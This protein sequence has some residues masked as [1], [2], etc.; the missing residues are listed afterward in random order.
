MKL[1]PR[2]SDCYLILLI[3]LLSACSGE[4]PESTSISLQQALGQ[5][6]N[7]GF[8][9]ADKPRKFSFPEDHGPHDGFRNEWWYLT[10][11]IAA[12]QGRQYGY[13]VTFFRI[14]L[15]TES[16]TQRRSNWATNHVWMAHVAL[17]DINAK[18]HYARERFSRE[19]V[20][21]A[22]IRIDSYKIWVGNWKMFSPTLDSPWQLDIPTED[23]QLKLNLV[24]A[25]APV[26]QGNQGLSQKSSENGNAS[27][28]Y[29]VTRL[30][31]EGSIEIHGQSHSVTGLSWLD[32]EWSSSALGK[33]QVGW[34][35]FSM[36]L[37]DGSD[38]MFYHLRN[39]QGNA[40]RHSAGSIVSAEGQITQLKFDDV[41]L[42]PKRWWK[43]SAG[44][45]YPVAWELEIKPLNQTWVVEALLDSQEMALSV[46]YWEGL[47]AIKLSDRE[48]GKGYLEM[49][50]YH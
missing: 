36:Q 15:A 20:G 11:N 45:R 33:D 28:Y 14:A 5:T 42:E 19:A 4:T 46:R 34:D 6:E 7:S 50:G 48:I 25:K 17:T 24:P 31:S 13:Q 38:L 16:N 8:L 1:M 3:A 22:G 39:S 40:D 47:V 9:F 29:S 43:N 26:L 30:H 37:D 41:T 44:T 23:F 21:L 27:Y 18:K 49:T 2:Y 35:W 10:G 32:R 12:G